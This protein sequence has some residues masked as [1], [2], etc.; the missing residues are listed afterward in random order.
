VKTGV[1]RIYGY[2]KGLDSGACPGPDPGFAGMTEKRLFRLFT[3]PSILMTKMNA[4]IA[5]MSLA[6]NHC[7][8]LSLM[9]FII[10][11]GCQEQAYCVTM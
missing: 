10:V 2:R 1:Q 8:S 11:K 4:D 9:I 3:K 5:R 7:Q 6:S